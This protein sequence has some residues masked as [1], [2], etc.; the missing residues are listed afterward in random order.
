MVW[1]FASMFFTR[2]F[3]SL[4][5][6]VSL[7]AVLF[8]VPPAFAQTAPG[9]AHV[10]TTC[11]TLGTAYTAD[12]NRAI[13]Q[14][15][16]GKACVNATVSATAT[17]AVAPLTSTNAAGSISVTNTFQSIQASTAGRN[18]CLIQNQSIANQM[19]V[20]FGAIG[21]ATKAKSFI[22]DTSHGLAI[23]CAVGGLGV[24]TDQISITGTSGDLYNANLQ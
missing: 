6:G 19:W 18:G 2:K 9:A 1:G 10:V 12:S 8:Y 5:A 16:T 14:D 13:T 22:L 15:T 3:V 21:T 23:S 4:L 24:V 17:V 11:G 7:T 20:Y